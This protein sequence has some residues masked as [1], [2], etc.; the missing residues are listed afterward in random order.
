MQ[1]ATREALG[2]KVKAPT[3]GEALFG[4]AVGL[5]PSQEA[6]DQSKAPLALMSTFII[7]IPRITESIDPQIQA[8]IEAHSSRLEATTRI[9]RPCP[10][11][12]W[13]VLPG[14]PSTMG[15]QL[16]ASHSTLLRLA[17]T[18]QNEQTRGQIERLITLIEALE[19]AV[20]ARR[21]PANR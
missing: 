20:H 7:A 4:H 8:Q 1:I 10:R 15:M 11:G 18:A 3:A 9:V 16:K 12:P 13:S 14:Q 2:L 21:T 6:L 17:A 19:T 5:V